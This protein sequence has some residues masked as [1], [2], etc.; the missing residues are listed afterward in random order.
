MAWGLLAFLPVSVQQYKPPLDVGKVEHSAGTRPQLPQASLYRSGMRHGQHRAKFLQQVNCPQHRGYFSLL[1]TLDKLEDRHPASRIDVELHSPRRQLHF[2]HSRI[3]TEMLSNCKHG[4]NVCTPYAGRAIME[5]FRAS[6]GGRLDHGS[7]LY[8]KKAQS[9]RRDAEFTGLLIGFLGVLCV[10]AVKM[11]LFAEEPVFVFQTLCQ[12]SQVCETCEVC[13][14]W[15]L[16][17]G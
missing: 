6:H 5:W 17:E 2:G 15:L 12:T 14:A 9:H 8:R 13:N 11:I 7:R 16:S 4:H 10:S 1:Q 3:I